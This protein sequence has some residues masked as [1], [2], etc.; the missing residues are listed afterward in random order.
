MLYVITRELNDYNQDGEYFVSV[1]SK[2]PTK[3]QLKN[4]NIDHLGRVNWENEWFNLN[5]INEGENFIPNSGRVTYDTGN[6]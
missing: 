1:F 2:E 5:I 4:L 6:I 3:E